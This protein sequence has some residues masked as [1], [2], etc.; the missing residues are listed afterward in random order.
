MKTQS[1]Y[2][3][4]PS[5]EALSIHGESEHNSLWS[6][7]TECELPAP[8]QPSETGN[9]AAR[10]ILIASR[11]AT[12]P[13][14][15][16]QTPDMATRLPDQQHMLF[17]W[18]GHKRK[19]EWIFPTDLNPTAQASTQKKPENSVSDSVRLY[20]CFTAHRYNPT[21]NSQVFQT[22][23]RQPRLMEPIN[24][25]DRVQLTPLL[26]ITH[27]QRERAREREMKIS[28]RVFRC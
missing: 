8:H 23:V 13:H 18:A 22:P 28:D 3:N 27:C 26:R 19:E 2:E 6:A 9:S 24:T 21:C 16:A 12:D 10:R 1:E 14:L 17:W 11:D 7:L 20:L 5:S 4:A 25:A 15:S